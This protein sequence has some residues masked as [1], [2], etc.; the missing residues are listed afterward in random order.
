MELEQMARKSIYPA[1]AVLFIEGDQPSGVY[2]VCSGRVKLASYSSN[3]QA[4]IVDVAVAGDV[5]G[6]NELLSGKSHNLTAETIEQSQLCFIRKNDFLDFLSRN[7]NIC[8]RLTLKL[9]DKLYYARRKISDAALKRSFERLVELLLS[10][11][12]YHGESTPKGI[13]LNINMSQEELAE[14]IGVSRRTL[15]RSLT[16]LK[17]L[18]IIEWR[19]RS[20]IVCDRVALENCLSL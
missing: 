6:V 10:L 11:C 4:V 18:R 5:V 13:R 16:N 8:W 14:K 2:C 12:Q 20:I 17:R 9:S 3:G 19:H 15:T 7:R 1:E